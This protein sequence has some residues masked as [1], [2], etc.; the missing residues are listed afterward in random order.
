MTID[1]KNTIDII[2]TT[3]APMMSS[4]YSIHFDNRQAPPTDPELLGNDWSPC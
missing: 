1:N 3:I 4:T 2:N